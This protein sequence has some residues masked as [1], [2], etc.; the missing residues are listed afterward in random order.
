MNR[1]NTNQVQI[2]LLKAFDWLDSVAVANDIPYVVDAGALLGATR[3]GKFIPWDDD[4]DVTLLREDFERLMGILSGLNIP[5]ELEFYPPGSPE[6]L[7]VNPYSAKLKLR[8]LRGI[9]PNLVS[10]GLAQEATAHSGPSIDIVPL[11]YLP[12]SRAK[13]YFVLKASR[14]AAILIRTINTETGAGI[15][16]KFALASR[17]ISFLPQSILNYARRFLSNQVQ[18]PRSSFVTYSLRD[19]Y[20]QH[21]WEVSD[22]FPPN[23]LEFEHR[24]IPVPANHLKILVS[25]YGSKYLTPPKPSLRKGH[26]NN[27]EIIENEPSFVPGKIEQ[28]STDFRDLTDG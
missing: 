2:G 21:R 12:H 20:P 10:R 23:K 19:V 18:S 24:L 22:F 9:E 1:V 5:E 15:S 28:N 25:L 7:S 8:G 6:K 16:P 27:L 13:S 14:F 11:D 4:L 17:L 26:F 3:D